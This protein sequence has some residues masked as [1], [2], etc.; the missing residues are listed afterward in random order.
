MINVASDAS[1]GLK[2][3]ELQPGRKQ[4]CSVKLELHKRQ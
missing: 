2:D 3:I 4:F 1:D